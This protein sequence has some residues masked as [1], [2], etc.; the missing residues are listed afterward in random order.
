MIKYK[1]LDDIICTFAGTTIKA[2][3]L[4]DKD[5]TI[6]STIIAI[7]EMYKSEKPGS[8][9]LMKAYAMGMKFQEAKDEIELTSEDVKYLIKLLET[10]NL[11]VAVIVG[12]VITWL[13]SMVEK[14]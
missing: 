2:A 5:L 14:N 8:G 6:R 4:G 1:G 12:R 10:S 7:C 3:F 13:N 9:E 11:F